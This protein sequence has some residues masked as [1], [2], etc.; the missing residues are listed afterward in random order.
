M[1]SREKQRVKGIENQVRRP[2]SNLRTVIKHDFKLIS[3]IF[4]LSKTQRSALN[5]FR[6]QILRCADMLKGK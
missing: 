6:E 3:Y 2:T 1:K 4:I 5:N